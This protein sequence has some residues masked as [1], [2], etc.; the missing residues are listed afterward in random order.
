MV[1]TGDFF[2]NRYI[3]TDASRQIPGVSPNTVKLSQI[4]AVSP[5]DDV[6]QNSGMAF[7]QGL[8][9]PVGSGA[10][11]ET[12]RNG[13]SVQ[14]PLNGYQLIPIVTIDAGQNSENSPWL[15]STTSCSK[16]VISSNDFY[17]SADYQNLL[18]ST[19]PLYESLAPLVNQTFQPDQLSYKNAFVIWDLLRVA[20]IHNST[21]TFQTDGILTDPVMQELLDL[22][23]SHEYGLAFNATE[24]VRGIAGMQLAGQVVSALE[25][26]VAGKNA[27][28]LNVQF[29][30]YATFLSYFGLADLPAA[31]PNFYGMPD[32]ASSMVWELVTNSTS[33]TPS[34]SDISVRFSFH[35]GTS[36]TGISKLQTYPLFGG[37]A[38]ELPWTDFVSSTHKF[39]VGNQQQ[40]CEVCGDTTGVCSADALS[41]SNQGS[42]SSSFSFSSSSSSSGGMSLAV[43]GV[44]G[45][46]VT[47]G[48]VLGLQSV[49]MLVFGIRPTRKAHSTPTGQA[50]IQ[51]VKGFSSQV[52]RSDSV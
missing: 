33:A 28:R 49:I 2:R 16:A 35:N 22:A 20:L 21:S 18:K 19:K 43:A 32:Y 52:A 41:S 46:M 12:L 38:T 34:P 3:S 24:P 40:R 27:T 44:I 1:A 45:A 11:T 51:K 9:P 17:S 10:S 50:N 47:L 4:N 23:N 30:S 26:I 13:S 29:G 37:E 36:Y 39:A 5:K 6:I 7:L 15:Q 25:S 14:A 42:H 48:V 31:D 8:Y